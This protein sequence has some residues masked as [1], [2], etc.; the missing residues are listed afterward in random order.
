MP[1]A[2]AGSGRKSTHQLKLS[3]GDRSGMQCV[4]GLGVLSMFPEATLDRESIQSPRMLWSRIELL[5]LSMFCPCCLG[6]FECSSPVQ[7]RGGADARYL[8]LRIGG[9]DAGECLHELIWFSR[10]FTDDGMGSGCDASGTY[11]CLQLRSSYLP[12][13]S[14]H[15]ELDDY[16]QS[17]QMGSSA[18][19]SVSHLLILLHHTF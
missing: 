14:I 8:M 16:R 1:S 3:G 7:C 18:L 2:S 19:V 17:G 10:V 11:V 9:C 15:D 5:S 13:R 12:Q 4:V 6:G